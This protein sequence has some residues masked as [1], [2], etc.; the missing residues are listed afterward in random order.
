MSSRRATTAQ[1]AAPGHT[2]AA[3][4]YDVVMLDAVESALNGLR[5]TPCPGCADRALRVPAGPHSPCVVDCA[6]CDRRWEAIGEVTVVRNAARLKGNCCSGFRLH[7]L[8][9]AQEPGGAEQTTRFQTWAQDHLLLRSGDLV[10]VLFAPGDLL[11][12]PRRPPM[13]LI[14]ANHTLRGIWGLPGCAPI[15]TLR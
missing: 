12:T 7:D 11:G 8:T 10:S 6:R 1:S 3:R 5:M 4:A 13:P 15:A 9:W 14:V 2:L